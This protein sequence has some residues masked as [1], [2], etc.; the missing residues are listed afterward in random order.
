[1]GI[2]DA[3]GKA[4]LLQQ[5]QS[6]IKKVW[7]LFKELH[8]HALKDNKAFVFHK[9]HSNTLKHL[10]LNHTH[11]CNENSNLILTVF[12]VWIALPFFFLQ[13]LLNIHNTYY[14]ILP[15]QQMTVWPVLKTSYNLAII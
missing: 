9:H 15:K 8:I 2:L 1:M 13:P 3:K 4:N 12:L 5:K 6:I 10:R 11:G 14:K 7:F